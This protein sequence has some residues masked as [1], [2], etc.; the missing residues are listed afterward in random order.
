MSG[1]G[2]PGPAGAKL[3]INRA[4]VAELEGALSGIGRRRA[5]GIVRKREVRGEGE[6]GGDGTP[7]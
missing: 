7:R 3:D 4:G 2:G 6:G 5:R 1:P